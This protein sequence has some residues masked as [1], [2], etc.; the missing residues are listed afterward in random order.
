MKKIE[1]E[2]IHGLNDLYKELSDLIGIEN[3]HKIY[4]QYKGVQISFPT[5]LYSKDYVR[6]V[7]SK[8]Y[9]GKNVSELARRYGYTERWIR[10]IATQESKGD[11]EI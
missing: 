7:V 11:V 4:A 5:R 8:E 9:D 2:E 1:S 10:T 3:M 6:E